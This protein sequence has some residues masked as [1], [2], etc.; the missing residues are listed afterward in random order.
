MIPKIIHNIWIQG[1]EHLPEKN[2]LNQVEIKKL[3]PDWD[4]FIWDNKM[5][6]EL[7]QKYPKMLTLY[8]N[9]NKLTGVIHSKTTQS[10]IARYVIL[11]EYGGLYYDLD[12]EYVTSFNELFE[13]DNNNNINNINNFVKK[14]TIYIANSKINFL[15]LFRSFG[16][17]LS[18][19]MYCTCFMAF[20]KEHPIWEKV[21]KKIE[22]TTSKHMISNVLDQTIQETEYP[23]IVLSDQFGF[24]RVS[25]FTY[26]QSY[27]PFFNGN[28]KKIL[29]LLLVFIV[30]FMVE[31]IN[32]FNVLNFGLPTNFI[33][34]MPPPNVSSIQ[35]Q[36]SI[37]SGKNKSKS[38][39]KK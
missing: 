27:F 38:R 1:Y 31:K 16:N 28:Y 33:P 11:K 32:H 20:E 21:L 15:E 9:V 22:N 39:S 7:L 5:I 34:G 2:K 26:W 13:F 29:L 37:V 18:M 17:Y 30:I 23:V 19:P 24:T 14:D 6:L 12:Y 4:F 10:E 8:K 3:N 36:V 25:E 35:Q